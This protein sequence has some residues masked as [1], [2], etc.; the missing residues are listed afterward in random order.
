MTAAP[1]LLGRTSS[2]PDGWS[3]GRA[4][5]SVTRA[6]GEVPSTDPKDMTLPVTGVWFAP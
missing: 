6:A 2:R 1:G 4:D 3:P 5:G